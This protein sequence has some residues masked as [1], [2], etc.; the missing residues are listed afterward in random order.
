MYHESL[1]VLHQNNVTTSCGAQ[2]PDQSM[3]SKRAM[4]PGYVD[5]EAIVY[6]FA[7][8]LHNQSC[9]VTVQ[10]RAQQ[11]PKIQDGVQGKLCIIQS[12]FLQ[13]FLPDSRSWSPTGTTAKLFDFL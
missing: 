10:D 4:Q 13:R 2:H 9:A 5:F 3:S 12:L 8:L 6:M 11:F 7:G 1:A